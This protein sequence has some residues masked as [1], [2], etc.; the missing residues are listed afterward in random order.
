M[1]GDVQPR[2]RKDKKRKKG[3]LFLELSLY[4]Y[5]LSIL[6]VPLFFQDDIAEEAV[7]HQHHSATP[8]GD[9]QNIH[10]HKER[11]TGG[12]ICA[13]FVFFV[14][15]GALAVIIGLIITEHRGL[16]D[17]KYSIITKEA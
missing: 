11:S 16:T 1:S 10:V 6:I 15:L 14:L 12:G 9:D 2:K 8:L 5:P 7:S 3:E 17:R 13:K 4:L